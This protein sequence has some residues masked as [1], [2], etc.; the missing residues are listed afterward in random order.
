MNIKPITPKEVEN[1]KQ[2]TIP[3]FVFEAT[4]ELIAENWTG[5]SSVFLLKDLKTRISL[6]GN[7][8]RV[9]LI[10]SH[11]LDIETTYRK[12]GW[13]VVYDSPAYCE[14]YE[15]SFTFTKKA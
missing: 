14:D 11:W 1:L 5:N 13:K 12:H 8:D 6:K 7:L 2:T 15:A 4:N 3:D 9:S 10:K